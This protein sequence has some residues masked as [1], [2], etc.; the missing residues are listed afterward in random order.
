[1]P[2][3][4]PPK[5]C[6]VKRLQSEAF[7]DAGTPMAVDFVV[8]TFARYGIARAGGLWRLALEASEVGAAP[9]LNS[10]SAR[11]GTCS[12]LQLLFIASILQSSNQDNLMTS[13]SAPRFGR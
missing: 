6:F 1:M 4:V 5:P 12:C 7:S 2:N 3:H 10:S 13:T 8:S 9:S 11:L